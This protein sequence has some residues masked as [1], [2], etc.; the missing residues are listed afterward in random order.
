M[1]NIHKHS[2]PNTFKVLVGNKVDAKQRKVSTER[3]KA[4]AQNFDM[5]FF[6]TSAKDGTNVVETF[7]TL[8]AQI[9]KKM[10]K[11]ETL[12][13]PDE[14]PKPDKTSKE[15]KSGGHCCIQ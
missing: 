15:K 9:V 3:G 14:P 4:A 11:T 6:E 7:H 12:E 10:N 2:T 1:D 8:A 13:K 5:P